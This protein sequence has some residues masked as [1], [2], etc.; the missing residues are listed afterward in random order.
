MCPVIVH[1]LSLCPFVDSEL[2]DGVIEFKVDLKI[3]KKWKTK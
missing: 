2:I 3:F 1:Q